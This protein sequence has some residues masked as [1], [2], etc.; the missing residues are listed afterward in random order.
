M[1][2]SAA[3]VVPVMWKEGVACG[4]RSLLDGLV[5]GVGVRTL[6]TGAL[7]RALRLAGW[8]GWCRWCGVSGFSAL[9]VLVTRDAVR[10][11]RSLVCEIV[12]GSRGPKVPIGVLGRDPQPAR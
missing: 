8:P 6:P 9:V 5:A 12:T 2:G 1:S 3:P 10:G 4:S 11:R 7:G